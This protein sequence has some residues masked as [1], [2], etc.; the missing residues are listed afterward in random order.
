MA[1]IVVVG[2]GDGGKRN[3][4]PER[5]DATVGNVRV[6][7]TVKEIVR[8]TVFLKDDDDVLNLLSWGRRRV[9]YSSAATADESDKESNCA[10]QG[11]QD[12]GQEYVLSAHGV[13]PSTLRVP[14]RAAK[15]KRA[16]GKTI[17]KKASTL[18]PGETKKVARE[19]R[20][21]HPVFASKF[22]G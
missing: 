20:P 10:N 1:E 17:L 22:S 21:G 5:V 15:P 7:Q 14:F 18:K 9:R 3:G 8:S 11:N 19:P 13:T 4:L 2:E 16:G 6:G 12:A